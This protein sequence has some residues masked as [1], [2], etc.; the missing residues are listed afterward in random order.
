MELNKEQEDY[1][2]E[3]S[4]EKFWDNP[5][6]NPEVKYGLEKQIMKR[7]EFLKKNECKNRDDRIDELLNVL[8]NMKW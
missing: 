8:V 4:R 3:E 2:L 6:D 5:E 7:I 1:L